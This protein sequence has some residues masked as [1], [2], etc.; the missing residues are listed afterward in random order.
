MCFGKAH[1]NHDPALDSV[2]HEA[3]ADQARLLKLLSTLDQLLDILLAHIPWALRDADKPAG[4]FSAAFTISL[5][6]T[7]LGVGLTKAVPS[8]F[9]AENAAS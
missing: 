5:K 7:A 4:H 3:S 8:S 1:G 2:N 9:F 6:G